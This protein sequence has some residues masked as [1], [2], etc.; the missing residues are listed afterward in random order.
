MKRTWMKAAGWAVLILAALFF[1]WNGL[2]KLTGAEQ[3][4]AMFQAMG[5]PAWM[6]IAVGVA[7][8][9]GG[10]FLLIPR[11]T[12]MAAAFLGCL[13]FGAVIAELQSGNTFGAL[14]PAQWL[15]LFALVVWV[16]R[17]LRRSQET[18]GRA[19]A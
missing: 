1:I 5:Y 13:M 15:V 8:T 9:V 2:Q 14:I 4:V 18:Q 10:L 11:S 3:M 7:E 6:R 16:R 17:R 12:S 19:R